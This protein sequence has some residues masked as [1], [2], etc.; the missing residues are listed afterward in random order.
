MPPGRP[1]LPCAFYST[2]GV[3]AQLM[4][5]TQFGGSG[6]SAARFFGR[7]ALE[8]EPNTN[9]ITKC[10]PRHELTTVAAYL[11]TRESRTTTILQA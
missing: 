1:S 11:T 2:S 6:A 7:P 9:T 8:S 5:L 3:A 10:G 4:R